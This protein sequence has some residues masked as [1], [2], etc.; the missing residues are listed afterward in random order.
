MHDN[1]Y[2]EE[3]EPQP[4]PRDPAL[5]KAIARLQDFFQDQ[6]QRLFYSTQIETSLERDFFHWITGKALLE[7]SDAKRVRR[8]QGVVQNKTINFYANLKHRYF[9]RQHTE[10]LQ[11]LGR[12]FDPEFTHAVGRHGELM[13]DAALGRQGFRA[14]AHT[15]R[16]WE[17]RTWEETNHNLDRIVTRDSLAYDVL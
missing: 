1:E 9:R 11:L 5:E 8:I 4:R 15:T 12:I 16:A 6:P 14:E 2:E 13:F 3:F 10:M 7:L 17:G